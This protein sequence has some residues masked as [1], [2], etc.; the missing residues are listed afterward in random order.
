MLLLSAHDA[1]WPLMAAAQPG[2]GSA[3]QTALPDG[4]LPARRG[5]HDKIQLS[6]GRR[7][8]DCGQPSPA[9][10]LFKELVRVAGPAARME[11]HIVLVR[12]L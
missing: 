2:H 7:A 11:P 12:F 6:N 8:P 10:D 9:I 1:I 5:P 4:K 3:A